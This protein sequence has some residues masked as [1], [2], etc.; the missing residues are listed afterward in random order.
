MNGM[1][2]R[3]PRVQPID[4]AHLG[5]GQEAREDDGVTEGG[6]RSHCRTWPRIRRNVKRKKASDYQRGDE[7]DEPDT[8]AHRSDHIGS[9][10]LMIADGRRRDRTMKRWLE[11]ASSR[12]SA[13]GI[14][15]HVSPSMLASLP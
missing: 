8:I 1:N 13:H 10:P 7:A 14:G 9:P 11:V 6:R 4:R 15:F 3:L 5:N 2:E 12:R